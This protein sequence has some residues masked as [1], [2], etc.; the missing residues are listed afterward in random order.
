MTGK[1][2]ASDSVRDEE[3]V[4]RRHLAAFNAGDVSGLAGTVAPDVMWLTGQDRLVGLA[5]VE[6]FFARAMAALRP[7]LEVHRLVADSG[8]VMA[9]LIERLIH[10]G[11]AQ[12]YPL[13]G[14]YDIADG[15]IV[16]AAIYRE[17]TADL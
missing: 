11:E 17:G 4:V 9:E 13:V 8:V 3:R 2:D 12:T 16:R 14:V 6:P 15:R 5:E 7:Q 10:D 1:G